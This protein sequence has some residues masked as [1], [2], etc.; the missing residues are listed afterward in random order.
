MK[1]GI[2]ARFLGPEGKGLGRYVEKLIK[3]LAV[4]DNNHEIFVLL[5]EENWR[6]WQPP[7]S[8]WHK[9]KAPWRWYSLSEQIYLPGLLRRLKLDLMHFPHF[10]VPILYFGAYIVTIHDL[11]LSRFPTERASTLEPIYFWL[12]HRVYQLVITSAIKR[13]KKVITVSQDSRRQI[14]EHFKIKPEKTIVTYEAVDRG[15]PVQPGEVAMIRQR[16]GI[17]DP[18]LLYVGNAYPHKNIESLLEA[19]A[20]LRRKG[21]AL[22]LLLV[23][24]MDYFYQ[25]VRK[26]AEALNLDT[27][28]EVI[29]PGF[30][31]DYDLATVYAGAQA[32]VFP[33]KAEGFGLPPLEAMQYGLPVVS[34][35][36]SC[37]P[38]ILGRAAEYFDPKSV[39][40]IIRAIEKVIN[41]DER[42]QTLIELGAAQIGRYSWKK[43]AGETLAVYQS[44]LK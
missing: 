4:T 29:F 13:A 26:Y 44:V 30:V 10:N 38:E 16:Y 24:K 15:R 19:F 23:G 8:N 1:I 25:R 5:R 20:K 43:M 31:S 35:N 17:I 6:E 7:A 18:Y 34:S 11:I 36:A 14:I 41:N 22:Q 27:T 42:R 12:K 2:D 39:T 21:Y 3:Y 9:V 37:L 40:D 32:Y 33:S 28:N